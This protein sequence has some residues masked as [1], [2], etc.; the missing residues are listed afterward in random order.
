MDSDLQDLY[1]NSSD[2]TQSSLSDDH[3]IEGAVNNLNTTLLE[4]IHLNTGV[5]HQVQQSHQFLIEIGV[6][7]LNH[8]TVLMDLHNQKLEVKQKLDQI[9]QLFNEMPAP[10]ATLAEPLKQIQD[11]QRILIKSCKRIATETPV[12]SSTGFS[13][14][15]IAMLLVAQGVVVTLFTVFLMHQIPPGA[16]AKS[17]QQWYAIFQRVDRL[18][19]DKHGN[20][21]PN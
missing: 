2:A 5:N 7:L 11:S 17:Q 10:T 19:K 18:Y 14:R 16:T 1:D 4:L 13:R 20:K 21:A 15:A 12:P 3:T 6:E 8:K 9:I